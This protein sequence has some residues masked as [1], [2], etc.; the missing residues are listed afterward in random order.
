MLFKRLA[1]ILSGGSLLLLL[2]ATLGAAPSASAQGS[3]VPTTVPTD[4]SGMNMSGN[5]TPASPANLAA[6]PT[7]TRTGTLS[8][9]HG[10][11]APGTSN[12]M[13]MQ[14]ILIDAQGHITYLNVD[15]TQALRLNNQLV[16]VTGKVLAANSAE[17]KLP[18]D[19]FYVSALALAGNTSQAITPQAI[20]GSYPWVSVLCRFSD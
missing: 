7:V 6:Q 16:T 14:A 12:T 13:A 18:Y 20:T 17:N 9:V 4:M 5:T 2:S 19:Q 8:V 11:P 10:D 3:P 1:S 15:Y